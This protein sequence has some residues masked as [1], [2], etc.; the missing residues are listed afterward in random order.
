[1]LIRVRYVDSEIRAC[2]LEN[3]LALF[4]RTERARA[5]KLGECVE[6]IEFDCHFK[7]GVFTLN[8]SGDIGPRILKSSLQNGG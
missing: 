6:D 8:R 2:I 1:M 7:F 4:R 3:V 5:M